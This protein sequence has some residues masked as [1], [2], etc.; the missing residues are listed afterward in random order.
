M[1]LFAPKKE[2]NNPDAEPNIYEK[3]SFTKDEIDLL[4]ECIKRT[5]EYYK[6]WLLIN[7]DFSNQKDETRIAYI[8]AKIRILN[9]LQERT[10]Y[11]GQSEIYKNT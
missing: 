8:K 5:T 3:Y 9:D 10:S 6:G 1:N 7:E 4:S 11:I 2:E